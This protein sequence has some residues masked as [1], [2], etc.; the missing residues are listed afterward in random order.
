M[1]PMGDTVGSNA[2]QR[3]AR[4]LDAVFDL[5]GGGPKPPGRAVFLRIANRIEGRILNRVVRVRESI[6]EELW[7]DE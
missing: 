7:S 5:Y 6:F 4:R 1:L 2:Y 3:C